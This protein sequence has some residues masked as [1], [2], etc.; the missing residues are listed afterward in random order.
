M[1]EEVTLKFEDTVRDV[2]VTDDPD[3]R[4][5]LFRKIRSLLE[6]GADVNGTIP[7]FFSPLYRACENGDVEL[8]NLLLEYLPDTDRLTHALVCIITGHVPLES[9]TDHLEIIRALLAAGADPDGLNIPLLVWYVFYD[10][11]TE[12]QMNILQL[13]LESGANANSMYHDGLTCLMRAAWSCNSVAV[14]LLL[15]HG[16]NVHACDAAGTTA[17]FHARTG[18]VAKMLLD[19]GADVNARDTFGR[20]PLDA[21][22]RACPPNLDMT[23][24]MAL[25]DAGAETRCLYVIGADMSVTGNIR[26]MIV[27]EQKKRACRVIM[28]ALWKRVQRRK[29]FEL[30]D[31]LYK[32]GGLGA[33]KAQKRFEMC[34]KNL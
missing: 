11:A 23:Y 26:D 19:A 7:G 2:V 33:L 6:A 17:L 4:Q 3:E 32:P 25:F 27:A 5:K 34:I 22:A 30:L 8:V 15:A 18:V 28:R 20:T 12:H 16:A 13:L 10:G 9:C 21:Y 1:N 24:V 14:G 29:Q 31:E